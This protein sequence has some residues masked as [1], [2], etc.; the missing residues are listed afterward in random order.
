MREPRGFR[1]EQR[2]LGTLVLTSLT[3][4]IFFYSPPDVLAASAT[5][6]AVT[7]AEAVLTSSTISSIT[8]LADRLRSEQNMYRVIMPPDADFTFR[9]PCGMVVFDPKSFPD[10][11]TSRLIGETIYD[12]PVYSLILAE[13]P[14]TREIVIANSDR[15][16]IA[17]V[18]PESDYNPYWYLEMQ[19]PDLYSGLYSENEIQRLKDACDPYHIQITLTLLP[20]DYVNTYAKAVADERATLAAERAAFELKNPQSKLSGGMLMRYQSSG[21]TNFFM[22][23]AHSANGMKVTLAYPNDYTN[24]VDFFTCP[25]LIAG[26]WDLAVNATNV[27]TSTN[28][29]EW[30]DTNT[31]TQGVRFYNAGNADLDSDGDGI[32]DTREKLMYHTNSSTND[33]DGDG[34]SDSNEVFAAHT[35]PNN[36]KTNKPNVWI[37]YPANESRKVWLP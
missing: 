20:V 17:S 4:I 8:E 19:Y 12:S 1:R 15:K 25:D 33:S 35:D 13:D 9:Q 29:I 31:F 10:T 22:D 5:T 32:S 2:L 34:L 37:S 18:K 27:Y 23:I 26:W 21:M 11:F 6:E 3:G 30:V 36:P 7:R 16:E 24:R 14:T 28:F